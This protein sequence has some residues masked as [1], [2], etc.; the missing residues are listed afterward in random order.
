MGKQFRQLHYEDRKQ[1]QD[2]LKRGYKK[3][4]IAQIMGVDRSTIY[5]ELKRGTVETPDGTG[6]YNADVAQ[7]RCEGNLRVRGTALKISK[8]KELMS[9]IERRILEGAS[10]ER[11]VKE[12]KEQ[13]RDAVNVGTIYNYIDRGVFRGLK[14]YRVQS[15]EGKREQKKIL[16]SEANLGENL[17]KV[18]IEAGYT[19]KDL[20]ES[21]G[22]SQ[23]LSL[24]HI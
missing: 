11:V 21:I 8:D 19:Q 13:G 15:A 24:I 5:N 2:L 23:K 4:E 12:L 10:P 7:K 18:R 20:A 9:Y 3:S 17:K 1:L 6:E 22:I 16:R 14:R